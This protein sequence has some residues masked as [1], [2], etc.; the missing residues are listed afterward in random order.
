MGIPG[1]TLDVWIDEL[2]LAVARLS[3]HRGASRIGSAT[4]FFF[5]DCHRPF[6]ITKVV[7]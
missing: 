4:G 2:F 1:K 7:S 6:L 3:L 5:I